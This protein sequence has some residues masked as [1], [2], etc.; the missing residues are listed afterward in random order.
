M[1]A[2]TLPK[3]TAFEA[4]AAANL[5]LL[6]HLPDRFL[7]T[8]PRFDTAAQVWRVPVVVAYP[9]IGPIGEVGE[10]N[11]SATSEA[12]VL[13]TSLDEMMARARSLYDQHREA[14]EAAFLQTRNA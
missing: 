4:Q 14:I 11:V 13:Y 5:F 2:N 3:T 8:A 12:I 7:A 9:V 6:N 10:I 1:V